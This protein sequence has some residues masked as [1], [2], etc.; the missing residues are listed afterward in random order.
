MFRLTNFL[1]CLFLA[2]TTS[3]CMQSPKSGSGFRLPD[4]DPVMGQKTFLDMQCNACHTIQG[5]EL[6]AL[7]LEAPVSIALGGP[8]S[9]VK[10]Y[11]QLVTSV[12]NPSHKL[13]GRYPKDEISGDGESLM[14]IMND[15]MTVRQL[16]DLVAFLQD[17]YEVMVPEPYPYSVYSYQVGGGT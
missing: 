1:F 16:V 12:I 4:G 9:R 3:A 6:P 15:F 10:T 17:Q 7:D 2:L 14:P 8:V 5:L 11:G 13:I